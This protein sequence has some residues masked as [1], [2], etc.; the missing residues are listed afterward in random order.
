MISAL[1]FNTVLKTHLQATSVPLV[2][3][4][5][6]LHIWAYFPS[7]FQQLPSP[8]RNNLQDNP[9]HTHFQKQICSF[10]PRKSAILIIIFLLFLNH[11]TV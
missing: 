3:M 2:Y 10:F 11:L 1:H 8:L 5:H 4:N 6:I 7:E 9:T